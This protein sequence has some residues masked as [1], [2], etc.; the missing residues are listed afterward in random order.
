VI[1]LQIQ[2]CIAKSKFKLLFLKCEHFLNSISGNG[3]NLKEGSCVK[4]ISLKCLNTKVLKKKKK[5]N[6]VF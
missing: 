3:G 4:V 1:V 2:K 5:T 6:S